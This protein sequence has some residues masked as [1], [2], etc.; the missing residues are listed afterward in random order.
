MSLA[1]ADDPAHL[2]RRTQAPIFHGCSGRGPRRRSQLWDDFA[3]DAA[4]SRHSSQTHAEKSINMAMKISF[5]RS[6]GVD[7]PKS[8]A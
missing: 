3:G 4:A 7:A 1:A 5:A 8:I 2:D 6:C